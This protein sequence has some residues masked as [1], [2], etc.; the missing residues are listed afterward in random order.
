MSL[1]VG[2]SRRPTVSAR[3]RKGQEEEHVR[4]V[5]LG[6]AFDGRAVELCNALFEVSSSSMVEVMETC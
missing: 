1:P 2:T 6:E 3:K 4:L 5:D